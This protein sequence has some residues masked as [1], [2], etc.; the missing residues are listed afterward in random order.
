MTALHLTPLPPPEPTIRTVDDLVRTIELTVRNA[1]PEWAAERHLGK[2]HRAARE[3]ALI[4]PNRPHPVPACWVLR[5]SAQIIVRELSSRYP[6]CNAAKESIEAHRLLC[7]H[8]KALR[9]HIVIDPAS[10]WAFILGLIPNRTEVL[11]CYISRSLPPNRLIPDLIDWL[12][13]Q[14]QDLAA[15]E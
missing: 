13:R 3:L 1:L 4:Y 12:G 5:V 7:A 11:D 9:S 10:A 8:A 2:I 6:P 14:D 15:E